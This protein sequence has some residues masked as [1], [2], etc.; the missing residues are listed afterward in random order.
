MLKP[1]KKVGTSNMSRISED[2]VQNVFKDILYLD[3]ETF[4]A[5][6]IAGR[7]GS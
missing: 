7:D 1:S 6:I 5:F 3:L 2:V 4:L